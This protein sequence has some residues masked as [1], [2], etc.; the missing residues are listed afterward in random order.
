[1][2]VLPSNQCLVW[3]RFDSLYCNF[4]GC[5]VFLLSIFINTLCGTIVELCRALKVMPFTI[6]VIEGRNK[7]AKAHKKGGQQG[8]ART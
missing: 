4:T 5:W 1:M 3:T 2:F 6:L 7:L 8:P